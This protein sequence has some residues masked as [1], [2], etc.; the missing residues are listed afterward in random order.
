MAHFLQATAEPVLLLRAGSWLLKP[1]PGR[2]PASATGKPLLGIGQLQETGGIDHLEF[3]CLYLASEAARRLGDALAQRSWQDAVHAVIFDPAIRTVAMHSLDHGFDASLRVLQIVTTLQIGG[4]ERVTLDLSEELTRTGHRVWVAVLAR[5]QRATYP[6]PV[7]FIDLSGVPHNAAARGAAVAATAQRA[8]IDVIHAHLISADEAREIHAHGIPLVV[9]MHNMPQSWPK[10]FEPSLPMAD[11]LIACSQK[12]EEAVDAARLGVPVRTAWNGIASRRYA[13]TSERREAA[14][15]WRALRGWSA[16]DLVL[17]AVANV[18]GQKRLERLPE[19]VHK[20]QS[21]LADVTVRCII[22][23]EPSSRNADSAAAQAALDREIEKWQVNV[24]Q[25]RAGETIPELLAASD[26]FISVSDFEGLSLSQLE[27]LAA[28]IPVMATNVGGAVE[29]ERELPEEHKGLYQLVDANAPA[30][31]FVETLVSLHERLP[32]S[33]VSLLPK[34][35]HREKMAARVADLYRVTLGLRERREKPRAGLWIVINNFSMGGAQSSARRLLIGLQARGVPGRAFTV[36]ELPDHATAGTRAL[37]AAGIPVI[38]IPPA[39]L[40]DTSKGALRIIAAAAVEPPGAVLFWNLIPACKLLLADALES[41]P[42]FDVSPGEMNFQ[43]LER[44][45]GR[46]RPELPYRTMHEYGQRLA[47]AVVK[48]ER[49]AQWASEVLGRNVTVIPNGV[50][51]PAPNSR[52]AGGHLI[53]GTAARI[54]PDK[55]LEDLLAA[56][57]Q[58]HAQLP[59]YELRIAG[60]V[61]QQAEAYAE[62]LRALGDR[63]PIH[64]LGELADTTEFLASLDVF[65]MISEPAGCPNASLEAMAAGL[66]VIA[67]DVGGANEQVIDGETGCLV[68]RHNAA[69][70]AQAIV[71]L[72]AHAE[73]RHRFGNAGRERI[74]RCFSLEKM[75]SQ[76]AKL[77]LDI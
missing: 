10:G 74:R 35:F 3:R 34:T 6:A 69:A 51:I 72:A 29:I 7:G 61:E 24:V 41:I 25:I 70:L 59:P 67:T 9:T 52:A 68:P 76:Y 53:F 64:W 36:E 4:A 23:G 48:Y 32:Q 43:S 14:A 26:L 11:L 58:A 65:V 77:C 42:C 39:R 18:R 60:R 2:I 8:N 1:L 50:P 62:S 20:F 38:S 33:R 13:S 27:A 71:E 54:S 21:R 16:S 22:A 63:L 55:R 19:I 47:G 5:A 12:V 46:P 15:A 17:I 40:L 30:E 49:E 73:A 66:P 37:R 45:F 44:Y 28:G 57:Q 56:F 31:M 75:I